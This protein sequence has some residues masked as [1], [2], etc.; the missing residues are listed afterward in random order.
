[1]PQ[2]SSGPTEAKDQVV[3][4]IEAAYPNAAIPQAGL[5]TGKRLT[6]EALVGHE[7]YVYRSGA[8]SILVDWDVV[9]GE[10]VTYRVQVRNEPV[11]WICEVEGGEVVEL[12]YGEVEQE[13]GEAILTAVSFIRSSPT[14]SWDGIDDSIRVSK[15]GKA[16][17]CAC[18]PEA[19]EQWMV[20]VTFACSHGGYGNRTGRILVQAITKHVADIRVEQGRVISAIIDE[21]WN[22]FDQ[23]TL[24]SSSESSETFSLVVEGAAR[25]RI[26]Q[27]R[28]WT[29]VCSRVCL[30]K[31]CS[32]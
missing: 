6:P 1:M 8:W 7:T 10:H 3:A 17:R 32:A 12:Y 2:D 15:V 14:F 30:S 23:R 31:R 18:A 24:D 16:P 22:E 28:L 13:G 21:V 9:A 27:V 29:D 26:N 11:A 20:L 5:W 4:F 25:G 19:Q